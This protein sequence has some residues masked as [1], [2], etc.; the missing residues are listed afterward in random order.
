MALL[1]TWRK[2]AY[3]Q[4]ADQQQ[5]QMFWANYFNLEKEI[6]EKI[7]KTPNEPVKGTVKELAEKY[8]D[9][10]I[11]LDEYFAEAL[12]TQPEPLYYS[13]DGVHP[14]EN[15]RMFIGKIYAEAIS[16]LIKSLI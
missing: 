1:E 4:N 5:L 12:K 15:G 7:L 14:N 10:Y 3:D 8:A 11:P 9:V 2:K 6:Y 13:A 16:P